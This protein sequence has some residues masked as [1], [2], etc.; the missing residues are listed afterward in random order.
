MH[1]YYR[2]GRDSVQSKHPGVH[3]NQAL[4]VAQIE[5]MR[6]ETSVSPNKVTQQSQSSGYDNTSKFKYHLLVIKQKD[7]KGDKNRIDEIEK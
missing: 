1:S 3:C 6:E 5:D 4:D 7:G 2:S